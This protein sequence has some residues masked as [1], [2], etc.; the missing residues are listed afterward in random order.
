M[1]PASRVSFV[2]ALATFV[3]DLDV[4]IGSTLMVVICALVCEHCGKIS[5]S[6]LE[7]IQGIAT[8]LSIFT[9][10]YKKKHLQNAHLSSWPASVQDACLLCML[11]LS[12]ECDKIPHDVY[13]AVQELSRS[14]GRHI[15]R[16]SK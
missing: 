5:T 4:H 7:I 8:K 15:R 10:E 6:P 11:R 2:T 9:R 12:A 13:T 16:V 3:A 1:D 14:A